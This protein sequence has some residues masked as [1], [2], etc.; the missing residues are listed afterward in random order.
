M[1][2]LCNGLLIC[3]LMTIQSKNNTGK[4]IRKLAKIT[5][6]KFIKKPQKEAVIDTGAMP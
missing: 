6:I 4:N 3:Y 5:I 1:C 2:E